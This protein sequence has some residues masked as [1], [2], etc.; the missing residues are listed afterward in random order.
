[1]DSLQLNPS[2]TNRASYQLE[3]MMAARGRSGTGHGCDRQLIRLGVHLYKIPKLI[4]NFK[5][6]SYTWLNAVRIALLYQ[7]R[8]I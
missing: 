3:A 2:L 5:I 7:C 6:G 4:V 1:M 8:Y